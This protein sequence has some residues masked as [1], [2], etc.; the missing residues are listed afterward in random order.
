MKLKYVENNVLFVYEAE[1]K[2]MLS[3]VCKLGP[4]MTSYLPHC[5]ARAQ[6]LS[7]GKLP[8]PSQLVIKK[9]KIIARLSIDFYSLVI[10]AFLII[11]KGRG[12]ILEHR[13][14][15]FINFFF[16]FFIHKMKKKK[17]TSKRKTKTIKMLEYLK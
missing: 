2:I 6:N 12:M 9:Q 15:V 1:R 4:R 5:R 11:R 8:T 7:K 13:F 3:L 10:Q 17:K 16:F 14:S